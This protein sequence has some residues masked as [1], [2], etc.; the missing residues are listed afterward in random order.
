MSHHPHEHY[1]VHFGTPS[2]VFYK[3]GVL[4]RWKDRSSPNKPRKGKEVETLKGSSAVTFADLQG[5]S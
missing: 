4:E 5:A 3:G 2:F 1:M